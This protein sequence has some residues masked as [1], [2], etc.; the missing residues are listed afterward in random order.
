MLDMMNFVEKEDYKYNRQDFEI[1][2]LHNRS[3]IGFVEADDTKDR[4]GA[5]RWREPH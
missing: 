4:Q 2:F 3:I 5:D 1:K